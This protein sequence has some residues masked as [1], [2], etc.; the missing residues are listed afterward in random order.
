MKLAPNVFVDHE[1]LLTVTL[2]MSIQKIG[3][4]CFRNCKNLICVCIADEAG[5]H[6]VFPPALYYVGDRAFEGT[7]LKN[8]TFTSPYVELGAKVFRESAIA[9]VCFRDSIK[10]KLNEGV[11]AYCQELK[12]VSYF[13]SGIDEGLPNHTFAHCEKLR[14]ILASHIYGGIGAGCF[15]GCAE[16]EE[17]PIHRSPSFVGEEA[18][19]GCKKLK[20]N[21]YYR[22]MRDAL[23][24]LGD[25]ALVNL[26]VEQKTRHCA[27]GPKEHIANY[28]KRIED[29]GKEVLR[30]IHAIPRTQQ[31]NVVLIKAVHSE[32]YSATD[33]WD[34]AERFYLFNKLDVLRRFKPIADFDITCEYDW[35]ELRPP[36]RSYDNLTREEVL[37]LLMFENGP[38]PQL[39]SWDKDLGVLLDAQLGGDAADYQASLATDFLTRLIDHKLHPGRADSYYDV[40][41]DQLAEECFS[42]DDYTEEQ[43]LHRLKYDVLF[44]R[45]NLYHEIKKAFFQLAAEQFDKRTK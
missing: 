27:W 30:E 15:Y 18:F 44:N 19:S 21:G 26:I 14:K 32:Y 2:P 6:S 22:T 5:E 34:Y 33:G 4:S 25:T 9:D 31:A 17:L 28:L 12:F 37:R 42:D 45:A 38:K 43:K 11:F 1:E 23:N 35:P 20:T 41:N 40:T 7:A 36:M 16:L 8:I 24:G 10:V 39:F 29:V 13:G 3:D